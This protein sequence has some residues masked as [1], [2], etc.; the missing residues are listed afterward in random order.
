M[1]QQIMLIGLI[2]AMLT[3]AYSQTDNSATAAKPADTAKSTKD[4]CPHRIWVNFGTAYSN[5]IYKRFDDIQQRYSYGNVLEVGYSYFFIRN[6]GV[7]LGVGISRTAAK[8]TLNRSGTFEVTE[9]GYNPLKEGATYW[10]DYESKSFVEKQNLWAI[11]VPLTLQFEGRVGKTKRNGLYA[12]LGV[13]GYFPLTSRTTF[14]GGD[15]ILTGSEDDINIKYPYTLEGHFGTVTLGEVYAKTKLRPSVDLLGEF[16]GLIGVSKA[17]DLYLGV[18]ASYGFMDILPKDKIEYVQ[19]E[20]D[21]SPYISGLHN[22]N[23]FS[24]ETDVKDKW[25]LFQVGLKIGLR[26]KVC[27]QNSQS[28]REDK[29]DYYQKAGK[30]DDDKK[31]KKGEHVYIIPVYIPT[32][33]EGKQKPA[34]LSAVEKE[35]L[36]PS[37]LQLLQ[38][39]ANAQIYFDL[40]KDVPKQPKVAQQEVDR[41]AT[42]LKNNPKLK[43]ILSGYTC[44]LG[45]ETH[46]QDL[47]QRRANRIRDMFIAKGVDSKQIETETYTA[48]S[49]P[50]GTFDTL[51]DARTVIFKIIKQ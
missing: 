15:I 46:N 50:K 26:F 47:A 6:L 25:N 51:E 14:P 17:T 11:E 35:D 3:T 10:M 20:D 1:K 36:D 18:Y 12:A 40:D 19:K 21:K 8:A 27:G 37:V 49:Y 33:D 39:L 28:M 41:A 2:F 13:K 29:R 7:G 34:D 43:V 4:Y 38:A 23:V 42:I 9:T 32:D 30:D 48:E 22:S 44:K 16:G 24:Y 31:G 5:N 45:T